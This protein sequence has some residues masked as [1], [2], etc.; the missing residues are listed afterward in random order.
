LDL[1]RF[2]KALP[3]EAWLNSYPVLLRQAGYRTGFIGK[4]GIGDPLP[5][6]DFD[7]WAGFPGQ[8]KYFQEEGKGVHLTRRMGHQALEFLD[9]CMADQP[10]CLSISFKAPHVQDDGIR[11]LFPPDPADEDLYAGTHIPAP[12]LAS[13]ETWR[14][15][16]E[17]LRES[18]GHVRWH[19]RFGTPEMFQSTAKDIYR[20]ITGVDRVVG[21]T[22]RELEE[23]GLRDNT[24]VVFTSD[25]GF[26]FGERQFEGKWLMYEQSIRTPLV[27]QDPR[28]PA[29]LRGRAV[30]PMTLNIDLMPTLVELAGLGVPKTAAGRSLAPLIRG[31]RTEW[32]KEWFYEH[33]L[34]HPRIPRNEGVRTEQWKYIR[35]LDQAPVYEELYDLESDPQEVTNLA[36]EERFRGRLESM[37][38]RWKDLKEQIV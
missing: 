31:E 16:P 32:R 8:G 3:S 19:T 29:G 7:Y 38:E 14:R 13:E 37:R 35:Y 23:R 34:D 4:F 17:F 15:M 10:F 21:E 12:E 36:H 28:L 27:I 24:V 5:K 6:E 25:N 20:L 30:N 22:L 9:G 1:H 26:F 2:D 18:E 11:R 33:L